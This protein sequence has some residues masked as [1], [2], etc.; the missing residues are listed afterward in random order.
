MTMAL[1]SPSP[2]KLQMKQNLYTNDHGIVLTKKINDHGIVLTQMI[3]LCL[4]LYRN[5][6]KFVAKYMY[7]YCSISMM[8]GFKFWKKKKPL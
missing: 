6:A 7:D 5:E 2:P 1:Y 3:R 4:L 8:I